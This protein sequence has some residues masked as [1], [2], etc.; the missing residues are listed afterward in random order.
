MFKK[1]SIISIR[2]FKKIKG[3][4]PL[5]IGVLIGAGLTK[6][7]AVLSILVGLIVLILIKRLIVY[8]AKNKSDNQSTKKTIGISMFNWYIEQVEAGFRLADKIYEACYGTWVIVL[9]VCLL[10]FGIIFLVKGNWLWAFVT[11][12]SLQIIMTQNRIWRKLR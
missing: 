8:A 10:V 9:N 2:N 12:M 5:F 7:K 1:N 3:I 6:N 4:L 11:L